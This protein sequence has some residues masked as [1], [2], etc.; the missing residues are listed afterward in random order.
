MRAALRP[1]IESERDAALALA[2]GDLRLGFRQIE[3][4]QTTA[5]TTENL[6]AVRSEGWRG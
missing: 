1:A 4:A 5:S 6:A 3:R 2:V